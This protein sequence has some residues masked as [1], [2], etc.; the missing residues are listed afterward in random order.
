VYVETTRITDD[1]Y[2]KQV[3]EDGSLPPS[4]FQAQ[5]IE[6][7]PLTMSWSDPGWPYTAHPQGYALD[8]R[9]APVADGELYPFK[10][11][12]L[13][14][15][16]NLNWALEL[17]A[18]TNP[19]RPEFS[20]PV[21]AVE[22]LEVASLCKVAVSSLASFFGGNYLNYKFGWLP[23]L[24]DLKK[25]TQ[26]TKTLTSREREFQS[27][28][29]HGGL[30]R[31]VSL[32]SRSKSAVATGQFI[33]SSLG[34]VLTGD[35]T[36][37]HR[38]NT[39]ATC[40]WFPTE[41]FR[42]ERLTDLEKKQLALLA[43]LDLTEFDAATFWQMVPFTWLLDYFASVSNY[44]EAHNFTK[45]TVPRDICI[46]RRYVGTNKAKVTSSTG[47]SIGGAGVFTNTI[48]ARDVVDYARLDFPPMRAEMLN[49]SQ[50][51]NMTALL[52]ILQ[53]G[54]RKL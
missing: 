2:L 41:A 54:P 7:R 43:V 8:Y 1:F 51:A 3:R 30:R 16:Q 40:R 10:G 29:K 48:R 44:L 12:S 50:L 45:Y 49:A 25:L 5:V 37:T 15:S 39:W 20:I 53:G 23:F 47:L 32:D 36:T 26:L 31:R 13:R 22:L 14:D 52:L 33:N 18:L 4:D 42:N 38:L 24:A 34:F 17:L 21:A 35:I 9:L 11:S 27:L 19:F 46:M 6:Y 28:F